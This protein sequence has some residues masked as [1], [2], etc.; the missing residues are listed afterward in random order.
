M[1][2]N[3]PRGL[4]GNPYVGWSPRP[5][6][7]GQP[8]TCYGQCNLNIGARKVGAAL[9]RYPQIFMGPKAKEQIL[10]KWDPVS[11]R[12]VNIH[13]H[14]YTPPP[15]ARTHITIADITLSYPSD[16]GDGVYFV[17]N[18]LS[19]KDDIVN[20]ALYRSNGTFIGSAS[21]RSIIAG[22]TDFI[23]GININY[24][25]GDIGSSLYIVVT[26]TSGDPVVSGMLT[27]Q[28]NIVLS[29]VSFTY[30][31]VLTF[32]TGNTLINIQ[33]TVTITVHNN[34]LISE[35]IN[36]AAP[37]IATNILTLNPGSSQVFTINVP[38]A[39][40]IVGNYYY[41][42]LDPN[43][44]PPVVSMMFSTQTNVI[45]SNVSFYYD[46]SQIDSY[47]RMDITTDVQDVATV[48]IH[49]N[50]Y[51]DVYNAGAP[52]IATSILTLIPP[53]MGDLIIPVDSSL[54]W[55]GKYYYVKL[56]PN[57]GPAVVSIVCQA[58]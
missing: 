16:P 31:P 46:Y 1:G 50:G 26:P 44:G 30:D 34:G 13:Q 21:P 15:P 36:D 51:F 27:I 43:N 17:Y 47:F 11:K 25:S 49:D 52:V 10:Q 39:S 42:K 19:D 29:T 35:Y 54:L 12:L 32:F 58:V 53:F 23:D 56:D 28:S 37:V 33:D 14:G 18:L 22:A 9:R 8:P 2:S 20:V 45:L 3:V 48:T 7:N 40:I 24:T 6:K 41:V 57:N 5:A 38:Y 55:P 4:F